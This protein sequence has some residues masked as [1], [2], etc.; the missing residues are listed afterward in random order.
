[1]NRVRSTAAPPPG[2][3]PGLV[4]RWPTILV[5]AYALAAF[6]WSMPDGW[7]PAKSVI[8]RAAAGPMLL[9]SLWQAWDMFSPDPRGDDI[10]VE[11]RFV[12]RDGTTDR[13]MLTD[14]VAMG[15]L[16]RWRK[17]RWRKYCND[18]L[19]LDAERRLWQPF[20]EC[21]VRRLREE[22]YDPAVIDLVRW[23]RRCEPAVRPELRADVRRT[24]W[25]SHAFH[26]WA[27]PPGWER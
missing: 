23:W 19:R 11:V 1:M 20:A 13:R 21:A 18:H 3:L 9:F 7:F 6:S 10:C 22:G 27:V 12:D 5:A 14:M 17:D 4:Q 26:R 16:E 2:L 25:Q 8:D 24:P 15:Y